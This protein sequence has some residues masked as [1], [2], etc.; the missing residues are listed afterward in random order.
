MPV[1]CAE[2]CAACREF[3]ATRRKRKAMTENLKVAQAKKEPKP[4]KPI[5]RPDKP[6]SRYAAR[7][8]PKL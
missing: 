6:L 7:Q 2:R 1:C 4:A 3:G 8:V 5:T